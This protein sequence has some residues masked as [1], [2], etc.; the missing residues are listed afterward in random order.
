VY[1][2]IGRLNPKYPLILH[3]FNIEVGVKDGVPVKRKKKD[4]QPD[5]EKKRIATSLKWT[6]KVE[7]DINAQ[8]GVYFLRTSP[9]AS[10]VVITW[11]F[12]NTIREIEST[13]RMLKTDMDLRPIYH[14]NDDSTMAHLHLGL[15][16]YLAGKYSPSPT[17]NIWHQQRLV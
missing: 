13:L 16:A 5:C 17:K 4:A 15:R 8:C 3:Y 9:D 10:S 2:R 6:L 11:Q 7:V 14:K 1:E 12:Y